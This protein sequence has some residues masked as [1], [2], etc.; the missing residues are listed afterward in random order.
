[1]L[2]E[3]GFGSRSDNDSGAS[4]VRNLTF[5]KAYCVQDVVAVFADLRRAPRL[6]LLFA[7]DVDRTVDR[8]EQR[9]G[10]RKD[11]AVLARLLIGNDVVEC[12]DE[13]EDKAGSVQPLTP[14]GEIA[15]KKNVI[16][17]DDKLARMLVPYGLR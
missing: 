12:R 17:D 6:V 4:H 14:L 1:M 9:V 7:I 16:E 13:A 11:E 10:D 2:I 8:L 5:C 15:R 3:V